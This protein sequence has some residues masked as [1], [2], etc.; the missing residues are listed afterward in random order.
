[1]TQKLNQVLLADSS[2]VFSLH[3]ARS[4]IY[5]LDENYG[6]KQAS[7]PVCL[8]VWGTSRKCA[9]KELLFQSNAVCHTGWQ[10]YQIAFTPT[11]EVKYLVFEASY[12]EE[13]QKRYAG[14][15]LLDHCSAITK[16]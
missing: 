11:K 1:M 13:T 16:T 7:S 5:P 8:R 12:L 9:D 15:I 2:Y 3:L 10:P 4:P 14:N 6:R